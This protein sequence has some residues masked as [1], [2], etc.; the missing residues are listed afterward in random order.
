MVQTIVLTK[1]PIVNPIPIPTTKNIAN[2]SFHL[3][4]TFSFTKRQQKNTWRYEFGDFK[5]EI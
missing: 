5:P 2:P 3:F 4:V 1:N